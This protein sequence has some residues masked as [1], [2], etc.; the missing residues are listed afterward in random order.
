MHHYQYRRT[1]WY[2]VSYLF[3]YKG[4][5]IPRAVPAML[6]AGA[7]EYILSRRWLD[8]MFGWNLATFFDDP[9]SYQMFGLVFGY[10]SV[11]R[12]T[13]CYDRYWEGVSCV[14]QMYACWLACASDGVS[15]DRINST[16]LDA[17]LPVSKWTL[18]RSSGY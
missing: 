1:T 3:K 11:H 10:L 16:E 4:S 15:F 5:L 7:F 9:F 13:S 6:L 12:L 17:S 14:N 18:R 2:G 8:E